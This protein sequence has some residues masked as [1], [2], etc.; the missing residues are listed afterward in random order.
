M[1]EARCIFNTVYWLYLC[2]RRSSDH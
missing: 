2:M 1:H